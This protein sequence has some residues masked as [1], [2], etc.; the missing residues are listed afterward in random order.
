MVFT[1]SFSENYNVVF[2]E[3]KTKIPI[4][5]AACTIM[6]IN[7]WRK[8]QWYIILLC[9]ILGVFF[10]CFYVIISTIID[11]DFFYFFDYIQHHDISYGIHSG[12]RSLYINAALC[13]IAYFYIV[14]ENE[15]NCINKITASIV[16]FIL[17]FGLIIL[18]RRSNILILLFDT[19][20]LIL[21]A[22]SKKYWKKAILIFL[23]GIGSALISI[24]MPGSR[25]NIAAMRHES[26]LEVNKQNGGSIN[27]RLEVWKHCMDIIKQN[28]IC[29]VGIGDVNDVL[30]TQYKESNNDY[31]IQKKMNPHNMYLQ[32]WVGTGLIGLIIFIMS[33]VLFIIVLCYQNKNIL[34]VLLLINLLIFF[35]T[36]STLQLQA[37][38][39]FLAWMI[40]T[41]HTP[42]W[43]K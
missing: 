31:L 20:I 39:M 30:L 7:G 1:I 18:L 14:N 23:I 16:V 25:T 35:V 3:L 43:V 4:L 32:I 12:Y 21:Y 34:F 40:W 36:E 6:Y 42:D 41:A 26:K 2:H 5:I 24:N 17:L 13:M 10:S 27:A 15:I 8:D 9:F 29:G 28:P 37:G 33:M 11:S 22:V 38:C 19:I